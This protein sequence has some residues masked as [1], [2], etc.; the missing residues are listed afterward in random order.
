MLVIVEAWAGDPPKLGKIKLKD[1]ITILVPQT[2]R[3]MDGLDFTQRYPSVRAPLAAYTNEDRV[4]DF[5]VNISATQWPDHDSEL[6]RKFF[7]A[8]I[9]SMFDRV[10]MISEGV[11]EINGKKYIFFEFES[12]INGTQQGQ[13]LQSPIM[14]YTYIQYLVEPGKALVF[15]FNCP[16]RIKGEWQETAHVMMKG[17]KIK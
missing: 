15:S 3:P 13:G 10:E 11:Q 16:S 9:S 5:S 4:V 7:K 12:R 1:G 8:S 17:I 6:A 14:K 2:W